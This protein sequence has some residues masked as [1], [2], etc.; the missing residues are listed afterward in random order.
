M[1]IILEAVAANG[2]VQHVP[3]A[4]ATTTIPAQPGLRYRLFNDAGGRVSS[5]A[6]V[7][8]LEGDLLVE[9]LPEGKVL[10]LEGF[11]TRCTPQSACALSM[12]N[13]GG[14][15]EETV[16]P[17]TA[18]VAALPE[19]GF[20][21]YASGM[22]A[23]SV[24]P[25]RESEFSFKPV[26]GLVGGLA[27][28]GGAGGGGGGGGSGGGGG[29]PPTAPVVTSGAFT[30]DPQPVFTG[31]APAGSTITMT[32]DVGNDGV[33]ADVTYR[34]TAAVDGSWT[35]DTGSLAPSSGTLP[36]IAEG[37]VIGY[38]IQASNAAGVES[39]LTTG[40]VTLD[41]IP[42]AAADITSALLTNDAT[43][44]I[45]GTGEPGSIVTVAL[46]LDGN[47]T[48]DATYTA[49]VTPAGTWSVDLANAPT[50]G[51]L[52]GGK[53]GDV[54]TTALVVT[55]SDLA[56]NSAP[57]VSAQL[58]VDTRI[59]DP[60][61]IDPVTGDRAI[62]A[63]E[64]GS[65][66]LITGT[67]PAGQQDRPVTVTWGSTTLA[68]TVS[69]LSWSVTFSAAQIPADGTETV[70]ASYTNVV[71]TP[72]VEG[73]QDVLIDRVAP[74]PPT[75][76]DNAGGTATGPVTFTFTFAEPVAGFTADDVTVTNGSKGAFTGASG[77]TVYTL[78]VTP[79]PGVN[80]GTIS[81]SVPA[82][83]FTDIAGNPNS[84]ATPPYTQPF[85]TLA[86]TIAIGDNADGTASGP[87]TFTFTFSEPVDGFSVDDIAV[88]NGTK[89]AFT[90]V[91][92]SVYT[93]VVTPAS[94]V[95]S[96]SMIVSV[97]AG[98]ATD[99]AGNQSVAQST[100][101]PIDTV[102][103]TLS[104]TDNVDGA[105]ANGPVIF[106]F[107]FSEPVTGFAA[108]DITVTGVPGSAVGPLTGSG[109]VYQMT[110]TPAADTTGTIGVQV[111]ASAASDAAG[112]PSV[113]PVAHSQAF[114]TNVPPIVTI[115]QIIDDFDNS[116]VGEVVVP[117]AGTTDDTTPTL[118][119]NLSEVF[120]PGASL[121][122]LLNSVAIA[123]TITPVDDDT[124]RFTGSAPLTTDGLYTYT[125]RMT[126]AAGNIG[127]LSGSYSIVFALNT[128]SDSGP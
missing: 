58:Q 80:N 104:I 84:A 87:V 81:V 100:T 73:R 29:T 25:P 122:V 4:A 22:T 106:T 21:M 5:A 110:V 115:A 124:V 86:P 32:L 116:P 20:L 105:T 27:I 126:D 7:R 66:I 91:S 23:S 28:V 102:A 41:T 51:T 123:G 10:A 15:A 107:T 38:R 45:G 76:T 56:G 39:P 26:L 37:Q 89:G 59:P 125:A 77:D 55:A 57:P 72:S 8:R 97:P 79:T 1:A 43:P 74:A 68:A 64:A 19:G 94:G 60:P 88:T 63:T 24:A 99:Q 42:P 18:P 11:F 75:I 36:P 9:G 83:R 127:P 67:L 47:G 78:V 12:D 46:D 92:T 30:N 65:P 121:E 101:Q 62:N 71:G 90:S 108:N 53:L 85:D 50:S 44:V 16:T 96:G 31:T 114:D 49:T 120:G 113:G 33:G 98:A 95:A 119:L 17:A 2:T 40:T 35:I 3:L 111:G 48:A 118:V 13:I 70:I 34:T 109:A 69:G 6:L 112:N 93:L 117:S 82:G 52:P 61:V 128:G 14:A 103:P 54:S